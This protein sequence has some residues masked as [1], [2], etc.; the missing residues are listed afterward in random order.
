MNCRKY[1]IPPFTENYCPQ[2]F[3]QVGK[4]CY[5][6]GSNRE[7]NWQSANNLCKTLGAH[8]AEFEEKI[9][10]KQMIKFLVDGSAAEKGKD[11]WLGGLNP[12]LLWIWS[13]SARPINANTNLTLA[14]AQ[15]KRGESGSVQ[16]V[17]REDVS[18]KQLN[19]SSSPTYD[20]I[21]GTGRCLKLSYNVKKGRYQYTGHDCSARQNYLCEYED[22]QVENEINRVSKTITDEDDDESTTTTTSS[23]ATTTTPAS[24]SASSP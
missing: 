24:T 16:K 2:N 23:A 19:D 14:A 3:T 22:Q 18:G 4:K 10:L 8:L 1:K 9:E 5:H 12:G 20:E 13:N 15:G 6:F 17:K 11:F 7:L 21:K